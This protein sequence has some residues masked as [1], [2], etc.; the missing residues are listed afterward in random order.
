MS[1]PIS[2]LGRPNFCGA[3]PRALMQ[4]SLARHLGKTRPECDH[5][6]GKRRIA[7]A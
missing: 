1:P 4:Y 2:V 7:Q 6:G 5:F 3:P